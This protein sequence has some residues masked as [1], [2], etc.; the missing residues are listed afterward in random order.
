MNHYG[1]LALLLVSHFVLSC[2]RGDVNGAI[3]ASGIIEAE[4]VVIGPKVAGTIVALYAREGSRVRAGDTLLRIDG[5]DLAIQLDVQRAALDAAEAQYRLLVKGARAEDID[6]AEQGARQAKIALEAAQKD[7]DRLESTIGSG[8]VSEKALSDARSRSAIAARQ[9]RA[10][11]AVARK[12]HNG[13]SLEEVQAARARVD[14]AQATLRGAQRRLDDCIVTSPIDGVITRRGFDVGE[15]VPAGGGAFAISR[16]NRVRLKVY[17]AHN[18]LG[19]ITL[20]AK[21]KISI[22]S[23]TD[24][25]FPGRVVY[26]S[27][28][29]E[30][31]PKNVQTK[32]DR[33]KLVFEVWVEVENPGGELKSGLAADAELG[34]AP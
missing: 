12:L 30:F 7:V 5:A 14:G 1:A 8:G 21:A 23:F 19:R 10:S 9:Y 33:T 22:D 29:A 32:D 26:I 16:I 28:T 24:R 6:Q 11:L 18:E 25:T 17:V 27:P 31:T 4:E 2:S 34:N 3:H 13:A 15:L 20:G